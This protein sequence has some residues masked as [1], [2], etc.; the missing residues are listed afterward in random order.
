MATS[1]LAVGPRTTRTYKSAAA[2]SRVLSG[3]GSTSLSKQIT[4]RVANGGGYVGA[5]FVKRS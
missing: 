3:T 4:R 1:I 2:A 5:T